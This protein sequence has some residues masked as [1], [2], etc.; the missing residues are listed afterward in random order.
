MRDFTGGQFPSLDGRPAAE[1]AQRTEGPTDG[2]WFR[3][4][5][6][7]H[8]RAH[9]WGLGPDHPMHHP[10]FSGVLQS[11]LQ[12]GLHPKGVPELESEQPHPTDPTRHTDLTYRVRVVPAVADEEPE[13]TITPSGLPAALAARHVQ[14]TSKK[15]TVEGV[16]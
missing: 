15:K 9:T 6:T 14:S 7:V 3:K 5:L 13:T 8:N 12:N 16:V 10:N 11:A 2:D 1:V 4:V